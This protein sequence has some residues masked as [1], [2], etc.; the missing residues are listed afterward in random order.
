[1]KEQKEVK[2]RR[3]EGPL[4]EGEYL[5]TF[6]FYDG[7][8]RRLTI[9]A[10]QT[11]DT[12]NVVVLT[13]SELPDPETS[14]HDVFSRKAGREIYEANCKGKELMDNCKGQRFTVPVLNGEPRTSFFAWTNR[15]FY[16]LETTQILVPQE[17]VYLVKADKRK[18]KSRKLIKTVHKEK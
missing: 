4:K 8:G 15:T 12:L 14:M 3:P 13:L 16:K 1:M 17:V 11:G 9:C 18:V 6:R 10:T 7:K 5:C 2:P